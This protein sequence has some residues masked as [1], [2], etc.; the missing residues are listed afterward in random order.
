MLAIEKVE[1]GPKRKKRRQRQRHGASAERVTIHITHEI[2]AD[3]KKQRE[4]R[5]EVHRLGWRARHVK[6]GT[7]G[8]HVWDVFGEPQPGFPGH[9]SWP[10]EHGLD[11]V[12]EPRQRRNQ[13]MC[14][15]VGVVVE[16]V[17]F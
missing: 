17:K 7:R 6:L 16:K 11:L 10:V 4:V 5:D 8:L 13:L 12:G 1:D 15:V 2:V 3:N 14:V 9:P